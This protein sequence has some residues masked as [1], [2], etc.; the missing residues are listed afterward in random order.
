MKLIPT[1]QAQ[2][3]QTPTLMARPP[4]SRDAVGTVAAAR[5]SA[6]YP[7]PSGVCPSQTTLGTEAEE[8]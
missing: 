3:T 6:S 5:V 8:L 2:A 4:L 7:A 1:L